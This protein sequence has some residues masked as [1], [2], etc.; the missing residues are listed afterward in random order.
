MLTDRQ[1]AEFDANG[2][3]NG[4]QALTPAECDELNDELTRVMR[5]KDRKD[6]PQ[7]VRVSS[8]ETNGKIIWQIVNI[9]DASEPFRRA[10]HNPKVVEEIARLTRANELRIWHDQ[11]QYKPAGEGGINN[12]HQDS[13]YWAPLEPKEQQVTAWIALDDVDPS[14]G[15]MSMVPGSHKWGVQIDYI[16]TI[17][18]F[19]NMPPEFQ[20]HKTI[21]QPCPVKKGHVHYHHAL[22]WHGSPAN[23]SGRPRRAIAFHYMTE[24]TRYVKDTFHPM[25]ELI[26][27][28]PGEKLVGERFPVV[29]RKE[30]RVAVGV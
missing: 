27:V 20:G 11:I 17:K 28:Q 3:L 22:T 18:D 29:W 14:N 1:I 10:L 6:V 23:P 7:P 25:S 13:P 21:A 9:Y 30:A 8:W 5:D 26:T 15:C 16:H 2:F 19:N 24:H 12:W 4:G